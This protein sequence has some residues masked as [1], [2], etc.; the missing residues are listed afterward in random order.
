MSYFI[1]THAHLY[2]P[3]FDADR[4]RVVES[5]LHRGVKKIFLPNIDST[6]IGPMNDLACRFPGVCYPMM[7]LHPTSVGEQYR[8][9]LDRVEY[10]LAHGQYYGIGEI[11]IDLYWDKTHIRQQSD[12]FARQLDLSIRYKLPVIIHARESFHEI[13]EILK[14][15]RNKGLKGIF[16]AFTGST[17]VAEQVT[18]LGFMLGIGGIVTYSKSHLPEVVLHTP[19]KNL[20]LETDAPYLTPVPFRGKRNESSY[21]PHIAEALQRIKN[22]SLE[23]IAEATTQNVLRIFSVDNARP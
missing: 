2:L 16:H 8:D 10:E 3:D 1:D 21:I 12:A 11:G 5:A 22:I 9:E 19:L 4:D 23:E 14:G 7:G 15:Y 17:F 6:S 20:V 13:L 18:G